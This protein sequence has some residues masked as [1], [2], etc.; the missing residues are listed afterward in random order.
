MEDI[1]QAKLPGGSHLQWGGSWSA[2]EEK[3]KETPDK[4][5]AYFKV[6]KW[7]K[8]SDSEKAKLKVKKNAND[9]NIETC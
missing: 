3:E 8:E 7:E 5:T 2:G 9:K 4:K 1:S 6:Q